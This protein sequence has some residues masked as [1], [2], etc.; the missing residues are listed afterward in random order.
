MLHKDP[1]IVKPATFKLIQQLQALPELRE[2][3][4][5]GGTALALQLGHRNSID[6][7]LFT[8]NDFTPES[9]LK[10]IQSAFSIQPSFATKNTLLSIINSIKVDFICHAYPL[11][12][13]PITEEG[14]TF[15]SLQDIA[16]MKLN[17]ISNSGKRLKDF[18]DVYFLLEHFSLHEMIE[19]YAIK[20]P[21]FNPLIALKAIN[22][23]EDIDPAIDPP[24]LKA[25]LPLSEIK[26][27]IQDSVLHSRKKFG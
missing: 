16:A 2:F 5:V 27:R 9:L 13:P 4:L 8:K 19:F 15:L 14:I 6:I 12:L 18:I 10:F 17:A 24:K 22:Y 26:K 25:K 1:F 23:F 21:R 3:Y 11:V 20:Y 7:D